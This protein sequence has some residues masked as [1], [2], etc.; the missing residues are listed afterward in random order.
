MQSASAFI[1]AGLSAFERALHDRGSDFRNVQFATVSPEGRPGLR[2]LIVRGFER[3]PACIELH[4]DARAGKI[5]EIAHARHVAILAW[6]SAD[7]LQLRFDGQAIL[8]RADT[9]A[10]TRWERMSENARR[11][12]GLTADPGRPIASPGDQSHLSPD[13]Q[14]DQ[15]CVIMISLLSVD[16][17]R[18]EED[19]G[20]TRAVGRFE[21]SDIEAA[22]I[23]P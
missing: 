8:H 7:R 21:R 3:S 18:L 22:W 9:L 11:A 10:R 5:R 14:F 4:S 16:V 20:Q 1:D 19:G 2:T 12:Y 15:F 13:N 17:L 23:G 6:S